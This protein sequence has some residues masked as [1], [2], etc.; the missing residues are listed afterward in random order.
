[1]HL[2]E[3]LASHLEILKSDI[4]ILTDT[5]NI[6]I[7]VPSLTYSLRGIVGLDVELKTVDHTVHSGMWGGVLMDPLTA[8]CRLMST[9][10]DERGRVLVP[11][12]YDGVREM[13]HKEKESLTSLVYT[14]EKLR[15][16]SGLLDG[17]HV[18]GEPSHH[19]L[20]RIWLKPAINLIAMDSCN[21]ATSAN[22]I[23]PFAKCRISCRIVS[24]QDPKHV[25]HVLKEHLKAKT[26][27]GAKI[28]FSN[29]DALTPWVCVPEGKVFEI[30]EKALEKGYKKKA[31]YTGCG[32]SIGF[33]EPFAKSFGGAPAIL[34][35][36]EDPYTNAHGENE[37]LLL[38]DFQKSIFSTIHLLHDLQ[39]V[40]R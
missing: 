4:L 11:G 33:V 25:L 9:L 6:D 26:P 14:E 5:S 15:K 16:E 24:N 35:G 20:E 27:Y 23:L 28:E 8:M 32:G 22:K 38:D 10:H 19:I 7:G 40:K 34:I 12:F 1:V 39:G 31:V 3:Y 2:E 17:V 36:I 30:A 21:I 18:I 13:T 37:S 29:E